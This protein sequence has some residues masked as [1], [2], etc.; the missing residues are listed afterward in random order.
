MAMAASSGYNDRDVVIVAAGR[1]PIG[2]LNGCLSSL[3]AHELGA[4]VIREV[5]ARGKI[6]PADVAEVI[7]GQVC[8]AGQGQ[9]PARQAAM[10]AGIPSSVPAYG[11]NMLCGSGLKAVAL[12][13]QAVL[14][15]ESAVIIAGGQESMSQAPH[16]CNIRSPT[17]MGDTKLVDTMMLDGLVDAFHGYHMGITAENVAKQWQ[18]TRNEQDQFAVVS[19]NQ[20]ENAQKEGHFKEEIIPVTVKTRKGTTN[21]SEDEFPR[22]GTS[23]EG[24]AHLKPCFLQDGTGSVTAGNSSGINDG[25]SA[26]VLMTYAEA[27]RR[28][29]A[30][31][32]RIVSWGQAGVEPAVMGTGPI[33]ATR[34][35]VQK[36]GWKLEDVDLFELN[37]AFAAQSCAVV[38]DLRLDPQKVNISGGAIALGHPIGASGCRILVTLLHGLKRTGKRTGVAALCIGGGMGIAMCVE[39]L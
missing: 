29:V 36:A 9:G 39:R 28:G 11:V 27:T 30:P 6:P 7:M 10:N 21:V 35:A 23:M 4:L 15:D 8:T 2:N 34:K 38:K 24:L 19:Q 1:T 12:G 33:P 18:V 25:S 16:C 31:L 17:K 5:L 32:A 3:K 37:E 22:H 26:V 13:Y 14:R 20:A